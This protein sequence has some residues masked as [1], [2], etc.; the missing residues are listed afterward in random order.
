MKE[1]IKTNK[2]K[3]RIL[4]H[5]HIKKFIIAYF[6]IFSVLCLGYHVQATNNTENNENETLTNLENDVP[7]S[8]GVYVDTNNDCG[9]VWRN[10]SFRASLC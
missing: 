3:R 2:I 10:Q 9:S 7:F 8:L 5:I 4:K 1:K 6:I